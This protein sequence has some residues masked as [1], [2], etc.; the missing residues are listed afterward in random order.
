MEN[1]KIFQI[2]KN[3]G[4]MFMKIPQRI[5]K[6]LERREKLAFHLQDVEVQLTDWLTEK[7]A[8]FSDTEYL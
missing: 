8:D 6:L 1:T 2:V 5:E 3:V 7:G 4:G